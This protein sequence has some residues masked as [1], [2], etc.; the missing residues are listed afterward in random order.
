MSTQ[1]QLVEALIQINSHSVRNL[2][3]LDK[4]VSFTAEVVDE[5]D[6]KIRFAQYLSMLP[7]DQVLR[8][9]FEQV[10]NTF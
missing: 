2:A 7:S 8:V 9:R 6:F 3:S 4:R 1:K 5:D 10:E